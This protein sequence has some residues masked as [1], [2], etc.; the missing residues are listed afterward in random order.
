M[1]IAL[2]TNA[3]KAAIHCAATKD[4]RYYLKGVHVRVTPEQFIY[5]ESTDGSVAFQT[6]L[7][8]LAAPKIKEPFGIIIPLDIAKLAI[9]TKQP[10]L[11]LKSQPDGRYMLGDFLFS[12]VD[13]KFPDVD[14]VMPAQSSDVYSG[15]L[16]MLDAEVLLRAQKALQAATDSKGIFALKTPMHATCDSCFLMAP[17][18]ADFPRCAVMPVR[19]AAAYKIATKK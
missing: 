5:V 4:V 14:R 6:R 13:G 15:E 12:A 17:L 2:S 9:K 7:T 18:D 11:L 19:R 3:I 8:K 1:E 16:P 10:Q